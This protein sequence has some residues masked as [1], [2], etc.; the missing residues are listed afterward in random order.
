MNY[1]HHSKIDKERLEI[2]KK[3]TIL[4]PE[5]L[6]LS[7]KPASLSSRINAFLTDLLIMTLA[8]LGVY[9]LL[10]S[11]NFSLEVSYSIA[12]LLAFIV[13]N[14]YFI[15]FEL[16][17]RGRTPGK[18]MLK[19]QVVN[20]QGGEL[21]PTAIVARNLTRLIEFYLPLLFLSGA[22]AGALTDG[23]AAPLFV[24]L[25]LGAFLPLCNKDYLRLG[26][27][28]GGTMVINKPV[29]VLAEDLIDSASSRE[30][31]FVFTPEQLAIYGYFELRVLEDMLRRADELPLPKGAP[32]AGLTIAAH[33]IAARLGHQPPIPPGAER[34]FLSDFYTA[35]RA[36][37]ERA[38]MFG[39]QK[40][41]Q[42]LGLISISD[43]AAG[44]QPVPIAAAPWPGPPQ[45]P[46]PAPAP[47]QGPTPGA[48]TAPGQASGT[49]PTPKINSPGRS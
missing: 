37:L 4:S 30:A 34:R 20:R 46:W 23:S 12:N 25:V 9:A 33:R 7:M 5:G 10:F 27:M 42:Y 35:Q 45:G 18:A 21:T 36:V 47:P 13:F 6:P 32:L 43:L 19:I 49:G 1:P 11:F 24:W 26:D 44:H 38:L 3:R 2:W 8:I 40:W 39:Q 31:T 17:W 28:I 16:A 15:Y 41:N 29:Q 14:L 22:L 48:G